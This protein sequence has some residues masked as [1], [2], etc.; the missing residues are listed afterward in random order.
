MTV[1]EGTLC[2]LAYA[3]LMICLGAAAYRAQKRKGL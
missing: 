3:T 2:V 1:L